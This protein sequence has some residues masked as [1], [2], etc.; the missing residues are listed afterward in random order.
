M[1][2][3]SP[4]RA[5][6]ASQQEKQIIFSDPFKEL[7]QDDASKTSFINQIQTIF[8]GTAKDQQTFAVIR[9][10]GGS[11]NY[12]EVSSVCGIEFMFAHFLTLF[13]FQVGIDQVSQRSH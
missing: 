2:V 5:V 11:L 6:A 12:K 10:N 13:L 7:I 8:H 3:P 1:C 9:S 4:H